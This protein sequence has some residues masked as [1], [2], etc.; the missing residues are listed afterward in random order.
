MTAIDGAVQGWA[1]HVPER[2]QARAAEGVAELGPKRDGIRRDAGEMRRK[3]GQGAH[4]IAGPRDVK[5]ASSRPKP[6]LR[7]WP[8]S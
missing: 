1:L 8:T 3:P 2:R 5:A 4:G 6:S 7:R